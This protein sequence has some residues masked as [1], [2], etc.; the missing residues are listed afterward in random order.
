MGRPRRRVNHTRH[1]E[2]HEK[3]ARTPHRPMEHHD[4][5]RRIHALHLGQPAPQTSRPRQPVELLAKKPA[6]PGEGREAHW[7]RHAIQVRHGETRILLHVGDKLAVH[8]PSRPHARS[9]VEAS[10]HRRGLFG[11]R[12]NISPSISYT[13]RYAEHRI[14]VWS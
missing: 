6:Y 4:L 11:N 1:A 5:A 2:T 8:P 7:R 13:C 9:A 12:S 10:T 14:I 3:H